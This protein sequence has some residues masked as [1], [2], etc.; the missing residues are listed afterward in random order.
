MVSVML[1]LIEYFQGV[2]FL[3]TNR[4]RSFDPAFQTRITV[5]LKYKSLDENAREKVWKNLLGAAGQENAMEDR[6]IDQNKM[7]SNFFV[8]LKFILS[9]DY[10]YWKNHPADLFSVHKDIDEIH[11]VLCQ[12]KIQQNS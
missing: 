11:K 12:E 2:L 1:R 9:K 5:A 3:T 10:D 6:N 8:L 4:V 7:K